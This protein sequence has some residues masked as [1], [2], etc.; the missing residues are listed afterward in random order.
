MIQQT[1]SPPNTHEI[2]TRLPSACFHK[3][4]TPTCKRVGNILKTG[5]SFSK[6]LC[7]MVRRTPDTVCSSSDMPLS[8]LYH[9]P[10]EATNMWHCLVDRAP[11][12]RPASLG[13]HGPAGD[14]GVSVEARRKL[15]HHRERPNVGHRQAS[16]LAR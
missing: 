6:E 3:R 12:L 9:S 4:V 1:L 5:Q 14:G 16:R 2:P 11:V 15:Q 8:S 10:E 13:F 7:M